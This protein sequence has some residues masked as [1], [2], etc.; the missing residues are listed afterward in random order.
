M[1][2]ACA[3]AHCSPSHELGASVRCLCLCLNL[4]VSVRL[5]L[6]L[7]VCA[8]MCLCSRVC[9]RVLAH[10][11]VQLV[12]MHAQ[13]KLVETPSLSFTASLS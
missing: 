6:C 1:A 5:N 11:F 4:L 3:R 9:V 2:C 13:S 10:A 8:L 12:C 7:F